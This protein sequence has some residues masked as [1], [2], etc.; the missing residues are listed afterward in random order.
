MFSRKH[1]QAIADVLGRRMFQGHASANSDAIDAVEGVAD[2]LATLFTTD[3]SKFNRDMFMLAVKHAADAE[4]REALRPRVSK[5]SMV[6][7]DGMEF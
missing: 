7:A 1:Y 2:D 6:V 4:L 3:N 5:A